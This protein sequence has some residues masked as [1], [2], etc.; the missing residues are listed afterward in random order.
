MTFFSVKICVYYIIREE[1]N[2]KTTKRHVS[3]NKEHQSHH[4]IIQIKR[5]KNTLVRF[6][7]LINKKLNSDYFFHQETYWQTPSTW[8]HLLIIIIIASLLVFRLI[9]FSV[10]IFTFKQTIKKIF[11]IFSTYIKKNYS[12]SISCLQLIFYSSLFLFI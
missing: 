10:L 6:I 3:A 11:K 7:K 1:K 4:F 2:Y 5:N 12:N 8:L 9:F